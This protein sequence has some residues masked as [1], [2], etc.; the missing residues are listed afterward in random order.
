[1]RITW[2]YSVD[3]GT[4]WEDAGTSENPI[5]VTQGKPTTSNM[6]VTPVA[7]GSRWGAGRI[8]SKKLLADIWG[9]FENARTLNE[10]NEPLRYYGNWNTAQ[11]TLAGLLQTRDGR[12]GTWADLFLAA[13]GA[14]GF[15]TKGARLSI[16]ADDAKESYL[17]RNWQF[18]NPAPRNPMN[19]ANY[20]FLNTSLI[21]RDA[22]R[23]PVT[24]V[25]GVSSY[26]WN[27]AQVTDL[28]GVAGQNND[29]PRS[30]FSDHVIVSWTSSVNGANV[31]QYYDP[32][33]GQIYAS[34]VDMTKKAIAGFAWIKPT[35]LTNYY[36]RETPMRDDDWFKKHPQ[37]TLGK[38]Q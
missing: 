3:G 12:C 11:G 29:N 6:Y 10:N 16:L 21:A 14:Q 8:G 19:P 2:Q 4:S 24:V 13:L 35:D 9:R 27:T 30:I 17:V 34:A 33:Y 32:S 38:R 15:P 7:F 28:A 5:Y 18:A 1:M 37:L 26:Q 22:F 31:T 23:T 36:I 20:P 25:Q